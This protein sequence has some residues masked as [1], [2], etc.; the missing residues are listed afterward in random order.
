[1]ADS[2]VTIEQFTAEVGAVKTALIAGDYALA[3]Q[4][5]ALAR[6]TFGALPAAMSS[7]GE[8]ITQHQRLD[9]LDAAIDSYQRGAAGNGGST[10]LGLVSF[11]GAS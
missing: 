8:A 7:S 1:V 6:I 5:A 9:D 11:V 10:Q 3:R 2:D 4:K